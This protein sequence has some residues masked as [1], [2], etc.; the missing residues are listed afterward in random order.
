ML[1]EGGNDLDFILGAGLANRLN[2]LRVRP[3][4]LSGTRSDCPT[5]ISISSETLEKLL[6]EE[7]FRRTCQGMPS[8]MKVGD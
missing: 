4:S 7:Y 6:V 5:D 2:P 3:R 8:W 1:F